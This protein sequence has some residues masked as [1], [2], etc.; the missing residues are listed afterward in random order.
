MTPHT[1]NEHLPLFWLPRSVASF[2]FP[3]LPLLCANSAPIFIN[4]NLLLT[5]DRVSRC[6]ACQ[7]HALL[8]FGV[9][10]PTAASERQLCNC[11]W[12]SW[13]ILAYVP[14][15]PQYMDKFPGTHSSIG[16]RTEHKLDKSIN[17]A[18]LL[19]FFLACKEV[20]QLG[21]NRLHL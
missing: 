11:L 8:L 21:K 7:L 4:Y 17:T 19:V 16:T 9:A 20:L 10:I 15:R 3:Q 1:G 2:S 13:K 6:L 12:R 18:I 14:K 5:G